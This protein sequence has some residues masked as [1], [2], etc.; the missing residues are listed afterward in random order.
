[1]V[2]YIGRDGSIVW[3]WFCMMMEPRGTISRFLGPWICEAQGFLEPVSASWLLLSGSTLAV[4][5]RGDRGRQ[6]G[7]NNWK[8]TLLES[9]FRILFFPTGPGCH[10]K[11]S[12]SLGGVSNSTCPGLQ[13]L[14]QLRT[15]CFISTPVMWWLGLY[16]E[17]DMH[18]S[19]HHSDSD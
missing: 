12:V 17:Q 8:V 3:N 6:C 10:R 5:P 11:R 14:L 4:T 7:Q 16:F 13:N 15:Q 9:L 1:M 2:V 18:Q 19:H